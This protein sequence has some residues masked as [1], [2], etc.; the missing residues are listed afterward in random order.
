VQDKPRPLSELGN[1]LPKGSYQS[2]GFYGNAVLVI[3]EYN[4]V[5]VRMLNQIE[6]EPAEYDYLKDIQSFGNLVLKSFMSQ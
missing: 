5:A 6:P 1:E 3:P 4:I 2:L